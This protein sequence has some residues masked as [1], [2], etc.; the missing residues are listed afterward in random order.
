MLT[1]TDL[2]RLRQSALVMRESKEAS[3]ATFYANLFET[4]PELRS[5]FPD[6]LAEQERKFAA[7]LAVVVNSVMDWESLRPV[8]EA[9]ARRHVSYGVTAEHY[10]T[11]GTILIE[12]LHGLGAS[13][14]DLAV[15]RKTYGFLA[16]HMVA[17]AYSS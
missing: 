7:T 14:D 17:T 16:D 11:V 5:M 12:T 10:P 15:W 2:S 9:L 3:A 8:V 1:Q 6:Q 4:A 13:E